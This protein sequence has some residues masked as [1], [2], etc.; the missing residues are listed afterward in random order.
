MT[1][2]ALNAGSYIFQFLFKVRQIRLEQLP[3][4]LRHF[5]VDYRQAGQRVAGDLGRSNITTNKIR[6]KQAMS[7]IYYLMKVL[8]ASVTKER[9][10]STIFVIKVV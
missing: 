3:F 2:N 9:S 6:S 4:I 8:L 10:T 7:N 5:L 1:R